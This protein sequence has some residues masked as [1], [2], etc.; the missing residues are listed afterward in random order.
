[1]YSGGSVLCW[2]LNA[3]GQLGNTSAS[4]TGAP[5]PVGG[6]TF[7]TISPSLQHTCG[8]KLDGAA[9]CWGSNRSGQ[10]GD[11]TLTL[12]LN[13]PAPVAGG[14]TFT[15]LSTGSA[16]TCALT[17]AAKA[18]CWGLHFALGDS[19]LSDSNVPVPVAGGLTFASIGAGNLHNCALTAAGAA[20]CW[21]SNGGGQLGDS[22][23]ARKNYPVAVVGGLTFAKLSVGGSHACGLITGGAAYCWGYNRYGQLGATT[24]SG[25]SL[26]P[27]PVSGGLSFSM[28]SAGQSHTCGVTT[29]GAAY[30]WGENDVGELGDGSF[31][32]STTTPVPVSGSLTFASVTT[33]GS[34]TCGLTTSGGAYCWGD[35]FSGQLG[36]GTVGYFTT[37]VLIAE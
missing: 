10:G 35:D 31:G 24:P 34:H 4:N 16:H 5:S 21:G 27:V 28:I 3:Q 20:Y 25:Y 22:T 8:I 32:E 33:G 36:R 2:G 7:S 30:C 17:D 9:Y 26:G 37:P 13:N 29:T 6:L 11:G 18:Y 12:Q 1:M 23:T 14:H 15:A 19:S